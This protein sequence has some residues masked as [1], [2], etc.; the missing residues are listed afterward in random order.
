[1]KT[2]NLLFVVLLS[3]G[4]VSCQGLQAVGSDVAS[5]G[6]GKLALDQKA[7]DVLELLGEPKS[8]G[9]D[10]LMEATG[11]WVQEWAFPAKGLTL[12]MGSGKQGGAKTVWSIT[13]DRKCELA[14]ARG[15]RIGSSEAEVKNAYGKVY[16]VEESRAGETFVAGSVYGGVIFEFEKGKVAGIFIGAAAE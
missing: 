1:M 16:N 4:V 12:M 15:V 8:K 3:F 9:E 14:T 11:E 13:A 7:G 10:V 5:E 2:L 6:L